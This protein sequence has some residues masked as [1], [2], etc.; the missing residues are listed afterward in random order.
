MKNRILFVSL[1]VSIILAC[2]APATA[3]V[4]PTIQPTP[5]LPAIPAT[6]TPILPKVK[7]S[8]EPYQDV[9]SK[10][11]PNLDVNMRLGEALIETLYFDQSTVWSDQDQPLAE[12]ILKL[13]MNPGMG[14][15]DLH[16][17]GITGKG[18]TVAIIDQ[19]LVE[20]HPEFKG[21]IVKYYD[22]G[23]NIASNIG[24]MH[25]PAVTSLLV[26]ENIGTAPDAKVY[27]VAAPSWSRDAQFYANA[28]DWIIAENKKLPAEGKIRLVSVSAA[29][30]GVWTPF[31]K[32]NAAWD[33]AYQRATEAGILVLDATFENGKT[34]LC[35]YDLN[36]PD[37]IA[38]CIPEWLGPSND[39]I[40][41][42]DRRTTATEW[43]EEAHK[44]TYQYSGNPGAYSWTIPYLAGV[45]AMGWQVNPDLTSAQLLDMLYATAYVTEQKS[46]IINP[47][48]FIDRVR[49][50]VTK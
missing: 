4:S 5:T 25:G 40:F 31:T 8:V 15:R 1:L 49:L 14:V 33:Q 27:F 44:F 29:P 32:N 11:L 26:G 2:C 37:N 48:A 9:R 19:P 47:R 17:A 28:I 50:S 16:A 39:R 7:W 23:T 30:S 41:I 43:P 13:G 21:K 22:V 42:P 38:K 18:V 6:T 45:L 24:S 35:H 10:N 12:N 3:S 46:N 36:D 20:D 34:S